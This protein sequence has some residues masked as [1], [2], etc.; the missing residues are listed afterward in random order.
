MDQ[1]S[2]F[3]AQNVELL[4]QGIDLID[5]I[6]DETYRRNNHEYF[7]SGIGRHVRHVLDLYQCFISR[8][9]DRVDY[10]ARERDPRTETD[11]TYALG[12]AG[13]VVKGLEALAEESGEAIPASAEILVNSNEGENPEGLSPW[14]G[15]TIERELQYLLSHTVHHYALIGMMLRILGH[16]PPDDFGVAPSTLIYERSH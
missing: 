6:D 7:A 12:R 5:A 11:R 9:A 15:S 10:D 3:L 4:R 16:K 2:F 1:R 8:A 14:A 13:E